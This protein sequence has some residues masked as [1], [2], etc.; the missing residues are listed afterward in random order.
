M[1]IIN[2][3]IPKTLEQRVNQTIKEEGFA[4][5]AEFFRFAA[6]SFIGLHP[7]NKTDEDERF[8]Y[9]SRNLNYVILRKY[10]G[11]KI[12]SLEK[13]MIDL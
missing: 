3:S 13:Q 10:K 4:S 9:L 5:K 12:K 7:K 2:F 8:N 6:I 11:R 1:A